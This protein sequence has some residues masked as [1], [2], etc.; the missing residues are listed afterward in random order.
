MLLSNCVRCGKLFAQNK[1]SD[2]ACSN[3]SAL[4]EKEFHLCKDYLRSHPTATL[5]DLSVNTGVSKQ[6][7]RSW[8]KEGRIQVL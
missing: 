2:M 7:L 6:N 4:H 5:D 1:S 8:I 3:C